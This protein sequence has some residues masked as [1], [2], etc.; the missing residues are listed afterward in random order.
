[1]TWR[2]DAR[3]DSFS[4][5]REWQSKLV[6]SDKREQKDDQEEDTS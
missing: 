3:K 2:K 6:W 4:E 5:K 1:M